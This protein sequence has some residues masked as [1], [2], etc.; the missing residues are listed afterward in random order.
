MRRIDK[1]KARVRLVIFAL[2]GYVVPGG[3]PF[4]LVDHQPLGH[5][6]NPRR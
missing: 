5:D 3:V 2:A 6:A 1:T 4:G